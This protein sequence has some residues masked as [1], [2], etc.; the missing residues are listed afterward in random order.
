MMMMMV[1]LIA[2][3][4]ACAMFTEF[5]RPLRCFWLFK[6]STK[7]AMVIAC[8]DRS[9]TFCIYLSEANS[10]GKAGQLKSG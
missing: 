8:Y 5:A 2:A 6:T 9:L 10:F 7:V 4:S 1:F 3:N